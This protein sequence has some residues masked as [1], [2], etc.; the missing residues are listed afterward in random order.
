[1]QEKR[2]AQYL[3]SVDQVLKSKSIAP[4]VHDWGLKSTTLAIRM[5]Q[6]QQRK[7]INIEQWACNADTYAESAACWLRTNRTKSFERVFNL[8]GVLLHTN[9][10]RAVVSDEAAMAA[11]DVATHPSSIEFDVESG[12]RGDREKSIRQRLE[13][14]TGCESALV[15]NNNAAAVFLILNTLA[16]GKPVLVSRGELVEIGGSFRLPDI[17]TRSGCQLLEVGTTNRTRL[18]DYKDNLQ[19]A[20]MILKVYPSNYRIT[21]FTESVSVRELSTLCRDH[22]IPCAVDVGSGAL[23]DTTRLGL[24]REPKPSDILRHG[25]DLVCFS[26][27]KLL[28]GPQAGIILGR[29][30]YIEALNSNPLKRVLRVDKLSLAMLDATLKLYENDENAIANVRTLKQLS[31]SIEQLRE[32]AESVALVL[33]QLIPEYEVEMVSSNA[34]IGSGTLT[35]V[36]LK[37][38]VLCIRHARSELVRKLAKRMRQLRIPVI[39]RI[40]QDALVLDMLCAEP[41]EELIK[42]LGELD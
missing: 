14:I 12:K 31:T 10:G 11:I 25:A 16:L 30:K 2:Q 38:V 7:L 35:D 26:G 18:N 22:L 42:N 37:T 17:M 8:T 9:L 29:N 21:G 5:L 41:V 3:P 39:G 32:R 24:P 33:K 4:I 36:K 23:I 15:V 20:A 27:D 34:Q 6:A 40:Q 13:L 1:M 19:K 28:G